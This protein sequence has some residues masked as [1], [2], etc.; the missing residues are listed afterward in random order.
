MPAPALRLQEPT[1]RDGIAKYVARTCRVYGIPD[2]DVEDL[3]Q[4]TLTNIVK[5][6]GSFRP[7]DGEFDQ[8]AKGVAVNV[9]RNYWR[10]LKRY[11]NRFSG[12]YPNVD[13]YAA[14][15]PSPERCARRN[16]ARCAIK[17]AAQGISSRQAQVLVL[18]AVHDMSHG[19][20]GGELCISESMSQK[21]YQRALDHLALCIAG[22]TF[23]AMPPSLTGCDE[24]I[25][26]N[27]NESR[28]HERA[29][30]AV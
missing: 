20:I 30:Y 16:Q 5:R 9:I 22:K 11:L 26:P 10:E 7:E 21:D 29:H 14:S 28:W 23:A 2:Q 12:Y 13:D 24:P 19:E 6:I 3:T 27:A 8:W 1:F 18:H 4:E 15:D 25:S 17:N